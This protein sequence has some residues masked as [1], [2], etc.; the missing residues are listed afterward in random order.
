MTFILGLIGFLFI[1]GVIAAAC[2]AIGGLYWELKEGIHRTP[3][4]GAARP[5][6]REPVTRRGLISAGIWVGIGALLV[7]LL[8]GCSAAGLRGAGAIR[9]APA[10]GADGGVTDRTTGACVGRRPGPVTTV[11]RRTGDT[12]TCETTRL[13]HHIRTGS[14]L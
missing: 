3:R 4:I 7:L 6:V 10:C 9:S 8:T 13:T 2:Q 5:Q 12:V 1:V 14:R 11:C